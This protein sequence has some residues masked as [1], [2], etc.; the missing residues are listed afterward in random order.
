MIRFE[1]IEGYDFSNAA[2]YFTGAF[3]TSLNDDNIDT[4]LT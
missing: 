1:E 3:L 2:G 4:P